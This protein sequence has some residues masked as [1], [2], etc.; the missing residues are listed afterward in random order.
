MTSQELRKTYLDYFKSKKHAEIP[1]ASLI[2]ENDPS[3]LFTTAGMHPLVPYFLGER[4]PDGK[5]VTNI[6]KCVR[7]VD[8]DEVGDTSHH[9]FFEML[10]NW[11]FGDYYKKEVNIWIYELLVNKLGFDSDRI[12]VSC[13]AGDIDSP[14]D[15][16][17]AKTWEKA[18]IPK[19]RIKFLPKSENWWIAGETGPCG[20]DSEYF[21]DVQ[22]DKAV[23]S[24]NCGPGCDCGKFIEIGNNVFIS[25]EKKKTG[26]KIIF[27]RHGETDWNVSGRIQGNGDIP[28][29]NNGKETAENLKEKI[30]QYKPDIILT[31]PLS[32]AMDTAK[33]IA[34]DDV[35]IIPEPLAIERDMGELEGL[36]QT[37][38][39]EQCAGDKFVKKQRFN[40]CIDPP[41]GESLDQAKRRIEK[42]WHKILEKYRGKTIMLVSHGDMMDM[43]EALQTGQAPTKTIGMHQDNLAIK[44]FELYEYSPLPQKSVDTG[45][46]FERLLAMTNGLSDDYETELFRPLIT[47]IENL[48]KKKYGENDRETYAMRVIADHLRAATFIIGDDH[49]VVSSNVEQGYVLRRL[50]RR[51]IRLGKKLGIPKDYNLCSEISNVVIKQYSDAYSELQ[52]NS[53]RI[54][55]ELKKEEEKFEKTLEKGLRE[56]QKMKDKGISGKEAFDLFQ[57]Y[58]FPLEMTEELAK[59]MGVEIDK[60]QFSEEFTK[61]QL[62][63]KKGSEKKF[64]GGL[65]DHSVETTRLHTATHLLHEALRRVLGEHVEQKGSNINPE[66]L[67]FDFSHSDKMTDDEKKQVEDLVNEQIMVDLPVKCETMTFD[68][69][70]K[71]GAMGLFADKYGEKV[72][73]YSVDNFSREICGGP[74]A[75]RTGEL[76]HFVIKKEQSSS[77]GVRRIKAIL[78]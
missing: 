58:G 50:I 62:A 39:L 36:T 22:P 46:G 25:Y 43:A 11:S 47:A 34:P 48:S 35:E 10:G 14:K 53:E 13:F 26:T 18:G 52:R 49:G 6:Q 54:I 17:S 68:E 76:G 32:R 55:T 9:T 28:L 33:I 66:R 37:E 38:V 44:E 4:H 12:W 31:S 77:S 40:Y 69:A 72:K 41:G 3:V 51:A 71:A 16:E 2:P 74:H 24:D 1:S 70:K 61:H 29:N 21:Y 19:E 63:S 7:V 75:Q 64:A 57:T 78:E 8:I 73:V 65:G 67:R 23:C 60:A 20:P 59:E 15:E 5:R 45:I 27:V 30:K 42:L 56:F